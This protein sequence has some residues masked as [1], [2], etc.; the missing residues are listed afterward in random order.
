VSGG[1]R[2]LA[3]LAVALALLAPG[4]GE[5]AGALRVCADPDNLPFS[6]SES[7]DRGLYIELAELVAARLGV[8]AE[9]TWWR[10]YF[11]KRSVRST[12]LS[13]RCDAFFG[14]PGETDFMDASVTLTR[15]F[16][17]VGY[18]IIAP[19]TIPFAGLDD[20][21][22][23]RVA[24]AFGSTP[25]LM[26]AVRGGFQTVTF[27]LPE[28]ALDALGRR[29]VDAA[30]VWGPTAGYYNLKKLG[31]HH[32]VVPVAGDGLQWKVAVG[33]RKGD[34]GLKDQ[35]ERAL[36]HLQPEIRR[37]A[38]KYG[39]PRGPAVDLEARAATP[40]AAG[41]GVAVNPFQGDPAAVPAG[42]SAFNQHC[43]R[44]HSP[45]AMSPEPSRDLRRLKLRYGETMAQVFH[46]AV[47]HG[48]P[49]KGMPRWSDVID[50]ATIWKM[51]TFLESVQLD[52]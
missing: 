29:E 3:A 6:S 33:V 47:T 24:V 15:P 37:L 7:G 30:F 23:R 32:H 9:Y 18:A 19:G 51:W 2:P 42:R 43:S 45:N 27:R 1:R 13:D 44:C 31:G 5:P 21:K 46:A 49:D 48:R 38:D 26:L 14:L 35:L 20:L 11:G 41:P 40:P 39:F 52:P 8:G 4:A 17:D 50:T 25:Q 34:A 36:A 10:T 16:L 28:E 22:S 12:L